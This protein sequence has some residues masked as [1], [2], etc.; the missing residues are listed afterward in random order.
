M[1]PVLRLALIIAIL[2]VPLTMDAQQYLVVQKLGK[3]RNFKYEVGDEI[4]IRTRKGDFSLNGEITKISDT[5]LTL[6][7][8]VEIGFSNVAKVL[9]PRRYFTKLSKLFFIR[10]GIAYVTIVGI[11]GIIN[12]DSPLIDEQTLT[13]SATMVAVGFLMKPFY[14]RKLDT[15]SKW[16]IKV[17]D[18]DNIPAAY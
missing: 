3:V 10:G 5:S 4:M 14:I 7:S 2:M 18:F 13:I 9:R 1:K 8:Y 16:K 11:N 17:I 15:I 6:N 12:N